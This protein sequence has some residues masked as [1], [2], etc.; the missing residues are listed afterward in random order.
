MKYV[1]RDGF[2]TY[3]SAIRESHP[4]AQHISD[5][6]HLVKN[7]TDAITQCIYKFLSARIAIPLTKE[8]KV[9]NELLSSK[10]SQRDKILLVKS[11]A[12]QGRTAQEIRFLTKYSLQTIR[13][14]IRMTEEEI[15][16]NSDDRRGRDHKE[17]IQKIMGRV[18]EVRALQKKG[19]SIRKIVDKTG[20]TKK[21]IKN[22][23]SPD[24]NPIHGQYGVRRP[25]KLSPFRNEVISLRSKGT[26]YKD[27]YTTLCKKGYTGSIAA[28][29]QF[30]AKEKRL[31]RD[32]KDYDAIS[33]TEIIERKWLLKLL[34]R[35]LEKVKALT[36]EQVKNV[37]QKYP[38]LG[39][40]HHLVWYFKE[41]LLSRKEDSLQAW[42]T[43]AESLELSEL[44]SFLNGIKRI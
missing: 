37:V 4:K 30:I 26:P 43:E 35:P 8:K 24:F 5:R 2:H 40:L 6:F 21:T 27:I 23:L 13:K 3:A 9:M 12:S 1:S 44:T 15:P 36:H 34:Y 33:S 41:I 11:L 39:K 17:A 38:L 18:E 25:G 28:I 20:H 19:Y 31:Q 10:P 22:Y 42:I 16:Q 14:Y 29:R 32:L 7:L